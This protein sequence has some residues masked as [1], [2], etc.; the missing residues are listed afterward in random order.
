MALP[1]SHLET[2]ILVRCALPQKTWP[3]ETGQTELDIRVS[4]L[5]RG[6]WIK[7]AKPRDE[8]ESFFPGNLWE[9]GSLHALLPHTHH[10]GPGQVGPEEQRR[11]KPSACPMAPIPPSQLSHVLPHAWEPFL[12]SHTCVHAHTHHTPC[13]SHS[14]SLA[15][16]SVGQR[17]D[18]LLAQFK[19]VRTGSGVIRVALSVS[20]QNLHIRRGW[21]SDPKT[22]GRLTRG[23]EREAEDE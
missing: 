12:H 6:S 3:V 23:W 9:R 10:V 13:W 2:Y 5:K 7:K 22:Q 11:K 18:T 4:S 21:G 16:V 15:S 14:H 20:E 19:R 1:S 17:W 8:V